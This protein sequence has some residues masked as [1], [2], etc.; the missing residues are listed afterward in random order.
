VQRDREHGEERCE[1]VRGR[2]GEE[3]IPELYR[4]VGLADE[5]DLLGDVFELGCE[6]V[7]AVRRERY[8]DPI[9]LLGGVAVDRVKR[10]LGARD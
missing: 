3:E 10:F 5:A 1:R 9:A 7:R 8:L 6:L 4:R 2:T